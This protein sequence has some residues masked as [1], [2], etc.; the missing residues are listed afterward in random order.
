MTREEIAF[1]DR[2][3]SEIT[4]FCMLVINWFGIEGKVANL[5]WHHKDFSVFNHLVLASV[6]L[7]LLRRSV[8]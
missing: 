1:F 7:S 2:N 6:V 3:E 4:V 8:R 5:C